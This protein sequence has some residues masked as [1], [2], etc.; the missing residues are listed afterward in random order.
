MNQP[1]STQLSPP[2]TDER[3]VLLVVTGLS[4]QI[5]TETIY[6]LAL[7]GNPAWV[8]TEVQVITTG[9]G[10]QKV[11]DTLLSDDPG[12]FNRLRQDYRLPEIAFSKEHIHVITR[13]DGMPLDDIMDDEDNAALADFITDRV[14]ALTAD[15]RVSLHVSIAGGRKTM[16]FYIGYALSLFGRTQDRLSH[17]L[18]SPPFESRSDFYYP[19]PRTGVIQRG[20]ATEGRNAVH[21]GDIPFVRLRDGL[22]K[23]LLEGRA[24]FSAAIAE[25]QKALPPLALRLEPGKRIVVAGGEHFFLEPQQFA[26]YWM[27]AEKC[28]AGQLGVHW[29]EPDTGKVLL[30][31]YGQLVG[32][33]SGFYEQAEDKLLRNF[34]KSNFEPHKAHINRAIKLALGERRAVPYLITKLDPI[35][36]THYHRFGLDLPGEV[37]TIVNAASL[38]AQHEEPKKAKVASSKDPTTRTER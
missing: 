11:E 8:P 23:E 24:T 38:R 35:K 15:P 33:N 32:V 16:G 17:V 18:V 19:A 22:P 25:A 3:R 2:E 36:G 13:P 29:S 12:W 4:P 30:K 1:M 10:K 6:A 14:R 9:L 28:Q 31:Y 21:M 37:I 26:V 27:L 34:G 7:K 5:V 20:D